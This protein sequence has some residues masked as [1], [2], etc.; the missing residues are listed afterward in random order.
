M[1]GQNQERSMAG[2]GFVSIL[3]SGT[4]DEQDYGEGAA[5]AWDRQRAGNPYRI[6]FVFVTDFFFQIWIRLLWILRAAHH[7]RFVRSFESYR[8]SGRALFELANN[9]L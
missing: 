7:R 3:R 2:D 1:I 4:G 6:S 8:N 5:G 9:L